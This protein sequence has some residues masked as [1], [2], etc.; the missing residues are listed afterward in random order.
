[1]DL[2]VLVASDVVDQVMDVPQTERTLSDA[3]SDITLC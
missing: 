2:E 1:M 3:S